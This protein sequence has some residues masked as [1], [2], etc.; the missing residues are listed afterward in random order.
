MLPITGYTDRLSAAA[1]ETIQFKVSARTDHDDASDRQSKYKAWLI[2]VICGDPNPAGP[3]IIE[4]DL[5]DVFS[6]T[7]NSRTQPIRLGSFA[8]IQ[9]DHPSKKAFTDALNHESLSFYCRVWPTLPAAHRQCVMSLWN[10]AS[11]SGVA[12]FIHE[13][14]L[15]LEIHAGDE[16]V[17]T[18]TSSVLVRERIWLDVLVNVNLRTGEISLRQKS[19]TPAMD[20]ADCGDHSQILKPINNALTPETIRLAALEAHTSYDRF[21]GKI[22]AP[23]FFRGTIA[24]IDTHRKDH[25]S[26]TIL[27]NWD[28]SKE[29]TSQ[30][31]VDCGPS[32]LHGTLKQIPSRAMRGSNWN[33]DEHCWRYA[34]EHYGAIHF[35]EDDLYDCEWQN[36]FGFEIPADLKSGVYAMRLQSEFGED[37]LPF[38]VRPAKNAT[39]AQIVYLA[40]TF[41]YTVY[42]NHARGNTDDA[43]RDRASA[44]GARPWT[45][46]EHG[47]YG[48]STYNFHRDG[49]GIGMA[50]RLRPM[51]TMRSGYLTFAEEFTGSGLRH[52]PA[53][54][55]LLSWLMHEDFQFDVVTDEDV[56]REGSAILSDYDVVVT[57]SH[58]EY[59]TPETHAAL[60]QYT[61]T[62][63]HLMYLGGNGFYWRVAVNSEVPGAVEIRRA[64]TG[65]RAWA[66]EPG[67]Y[68][69]ALDGGYGGTW[70]RNNK[71]PQQLAGVGFSGQGKFQ[72]SYY[73]RNRDLPASI[74]EW[75][76]AGINEDKIGDFGLSG[77]GAAGYEVDRVDRRLGTP[78]QTHILATSE[79]HQQHFML[80][81]E[82]HLTHV[83]TWPGETTENIAN[84]IRADLV[85]FETA[86]GGGVFSTG[87]ITWCGSL[88]THN[89]ENNVAKLTGNVLRHFV[90]KP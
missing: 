36:D 29:I 64:E 28:F 86:G 46:D 57:S 81:P 18:A 60:S 19:H 41:T 76:F 11:D 42:G 79:N 84:L 6:V 59:H 69:H 53:D 54:T 72:G 62:G 23:A 17:Q 65:I 31:V 4:E 45:P 9:L 71:P 47:E 44:W 67:E 58:P 3:G 12:L 68:Y 20:N 2:R 80:V 21:N 73:R 70:R 13:Q 39:K 49:S 5:S 87:S 90:Q 52:F 7:C 63:G 15:L 33:G 22:E 27:A 75:V 78:D 83:Y 37:M 38:F 82:E 77:G 26:S 48:Y 30:K 35:H 55:H 85:Y 51:I 10:D 16:S 50:S 8:E 56:H 24:D 74:A 34:P 89:Y 61:A 25:D 43:Y 14:R 40:P 1:G 32:Q 66:A 88:P